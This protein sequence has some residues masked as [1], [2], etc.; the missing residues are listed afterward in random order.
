MFLQI[1]KTEKRNKALR[2]RESDGESGPLAGL[3]GEGNL[4]VV[5]LDNLGYIV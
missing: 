1:R 5:Q 2:Q 4:A 3:A